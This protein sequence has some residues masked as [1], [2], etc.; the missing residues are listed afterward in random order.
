MS[1]EQ[2]GAQMVTHGYANL[3]RSLMYLV[4]ASWPNIVINWHNTHPHPNWNIG[5]QSNGSSHDLLNNELNNYCDADLASDLDRKPISS[6]VITS[7]LEFEETNHT[8]TINTWGQVHCSSTHCETS[9]WYQSLLMELK[10]PLTT[11]LTIFSI[12]QSAISIAHHPEFYTCTKHIDITVHFLCDHVKKGTLDLHYINTEYNLADIFT[13]ALRKLSH[14][15]FT[16]E[17]GV[18]SG[19]GGVL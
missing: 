3:I 16:F 18:L 9:F 10:F 8:S 19:Q 17:L 1:E 7:S 11:P 12:N 15:N 4:I 5:Q 6:Y 13:K 14:I 2:G